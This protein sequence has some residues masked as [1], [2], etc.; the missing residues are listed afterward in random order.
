[1]RPTESLGHCGGPRLD[2]SSLVPP[3]TYSR[4]I[5]E[6]ED[7]LDVDAARVAM[8]E[9]EDRI[10]YADVRRRLGLDDEQKAKRK[11]AQPRAKTR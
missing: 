3:Y 7:R 5:E 4:L 9:S 11:R 6:V 8:A 1:M 10:P 2:E